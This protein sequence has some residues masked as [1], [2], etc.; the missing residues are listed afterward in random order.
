[1]NENVSQKTSKS[2]KTFILKLQLQQY[3]E[4]M[5]FALPT[6][7][8]LNASPRMR[9]PEVLKIARCLRK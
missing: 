2:K 6:S 4:L 5:L 1:M 3:I 8:A 9:I 7:D